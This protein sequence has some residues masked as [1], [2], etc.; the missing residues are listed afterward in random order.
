MLSSLS[1]GGDANDL[2]RTSLKDQE[3]ANPNVV[4]RDGDGVWWT[5]ALYIAHMATWTIVHTDVKVYFLT[6]WV[7]TVVMMVVMMVTLMVTLM[8]AVAIVTS[9]DWVSDAFF[10]TVRCTRGAVSERV[11]MAVFVVITHVCSWSRGTVDG[12]FFYVDVL[13]GRRVVVALFYVLV[14]N[15]GCSSSTE[16]SFSKVDSCVVTRSLVTN[17]TIFAVVST[18]FTKVGF[19]VTLIGFSVTR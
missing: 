1:G 6:N 10:E 16:V 7:D 15:E 13:L 17:S 18:V 8:V 14:G 11:I 19:G 5:G 3:I 12:V 9:V 2:A 4:A